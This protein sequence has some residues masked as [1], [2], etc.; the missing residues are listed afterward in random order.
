MKNYQKEERQ[1]RRDF[2]RQSACA[3]LGVSAIVNTLAQMRLMTAAMGQEGLV[4]TEYKAMVCL[5]MNGGNDSNNMIFPIGIAE[6]DELRADYEQ[7]R[8]VLALPRTQS[9]GSELTDTALNLPDGSGELDKC[10]AFDKHHGGEIHPIAVHPSAA[11]M[12]E[13][14][15]DGDLAF[16]CNVGTLAEPIPN[17]DAYVNRLVN[18]PTQL[19]SHSNQ[20][21]QWQSSIADQTFTSGWGGRVADLLNASYNDS[22]KVSMSISLKG[23]NSFQTGI[24]GGVSQYIVNSSG[25]VSLDGYGTNTKPYKYA[26][27]NTVD[28][29]DGYKATNQGRQLQA[30]NDILDLTHENLLEENYQQIVRSAR[31]TEGVVGAA[32]TAASQTGVDF[33]LKFANAKSSLG[34]QLK[35]IAKLIAGRS[36]LGNSRQIYFCE[37]S[38]YDTHSSL[39]A[40][41]AELMEELS[42]ALKAFRDTLKDPAIDIFDQV[43]TFTAS[44]F[45]RTLT[46]NGT[47]ASAGSDHAWGGHTI[48]MGGA[49]KGGQLYGSFPSLKVG[50]QIGSIDSHKSRGRLIPDISVDQYSSVLANWFGVDSNARELIFPNFARFDDP[51]SVAST[52]L[53]FL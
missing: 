25:A 29:T 47:S 16:V 45:N 21:T 48:V 4:N 17:R 35:T 39:Q 31:A 44:D 38:G 14:F 30:F 15:N 10:R 43:T 11:P 33:D 40:S 6:D 36:A 20:Q 27:Q 46:P 49:V 37:I 41:H 19:F 5:F 28:V 3:S 13:M 26:Y 9:D 7:A 18:L 12:A 53:D 42:N 8:G 52:N 34:D 51:F 32:L 24:G 2:L 23:V 1:T 50:D 22:G